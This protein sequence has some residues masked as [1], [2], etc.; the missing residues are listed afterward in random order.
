[1]SATAPIA[2][3]AS[4]AFLGQMILNFPPHELQRLLDDIDNPVSFIIAADGANV[5]VGSQVLPQDNPNYPILNETDAA[6]KRT[7]IIEEILSQTARG[8]NG[9]KIFKRR[10]NGSEETFTLAYEPVRARAL[11]P[12]DPTDLSRGCSVDYVTIYTVGLAYSKTEFEKPWKTVEAGIDSQLHQLR[13]I[14]ISIIC[15]ALSIFAL[16]ACMVSLSIF[17]PL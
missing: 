11:L 9:T 8:Q 1:M 16:F 2:N 12:L 17:L 13:N 14:Y 7:N 6:E 3:P 10:N 4:G 5:A 15:V